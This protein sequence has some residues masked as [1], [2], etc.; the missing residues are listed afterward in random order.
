M[1]KSSN[2]SIR[3][4]QTCQ[5][6]R[7][8][9]HGGNFSPRI[10]SEKGSC[11]TDSPSITRVGEKLLRVSMQWLGGNPAAFQEYRDRTSKWLCFGFQLGTHIRNSYRSRDFR[12]PVGHI[13]FRNYK[14]WPQTGLFF[15]GIK[16]SCLPGDWAL[17]VKP[18]RRNCYKVP[19]TSLS[20]S[21]NVKRC[22]ISLGHLS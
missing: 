1:F 6:S 11:N 18:K 17:H 5:R 15:P 9:G 7:F 14:T 4:K 10:G 3:V 22:P 8:S 16:L 19:K 2:E 21:R 20:S 13:G 12:N